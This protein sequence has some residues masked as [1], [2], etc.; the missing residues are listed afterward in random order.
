MAK[1]KKK[2]VVTEVAEVV[3]TEAVSEAVVPEVVNVTDDVV[4]DVVTDVTEE[5][6]PEDTEVTPEVDLLT[7][8]AD[9]YGTDKGSTAHNFTP[10]YNKYFKDIREDVKKVVEIGVHNGYSI[11]MW[12]DYFPNAEVVGADIKV[13]NIGYHPRVK[14]K[15]IDCGSRWQLN[16]FVEAKEADV[17]VDDGSHFMDHQQVSLAVLFRMLKSGG[18]YILEDLHSSFLPDFVGKYTN[19]LTYDLV[20]RLVNKEFKKNKFISDDEQKYILENIEFVEIYKQN[21]GN[22]IT[23]MIKKI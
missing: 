6:T 18:Y 12:A 9:G 3:N 10:F 7:T 23:C 2:K 20:E 21:D 15:T 14:L 16:R 13:L 19:D 8:L 22:S 17:I 11:K 4:T 1:V 5:A